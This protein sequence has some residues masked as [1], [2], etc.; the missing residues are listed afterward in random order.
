[1]Y[2]L[3][4]NLCIRRWNWL[5]GVIGC[6]DI[7][8]LTVKMTVGL[9]ERSDWADDFTGSY[10]FLKG[11]GSW[12]AKW[13]W[14][15]KGR[16][17]AGA[18]CVPL[19]RGDGCS[20]TRGEQ[21]P[22][23]QKLGRSVLKWTVPQADVYVVYNPGRL[24]TEFLSSEWSW[25][26]VPS[27]GKNMANEGHPSAKERRASW[28]DRSLHWQAPANQEKQALACIS[29]FRKWQQLRENTFCNQ[30]SNLAEV[31]IVPTV[32]F[33][34]SQLKHMPMKLAFALRVSWWVFQT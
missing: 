21:M 23:E 27:T 33:S 8:I 19:G 10:S 14:T 30:F 31:I 29:P 7:G 12:L 16:K 28:R 22:W 24:W 34:I 9:K 4:G 20:S 25:V 18:F 15:R 1:M 3:A 17:D 11:K 2:P 26:S 32:L 6:L 13:A 5:L